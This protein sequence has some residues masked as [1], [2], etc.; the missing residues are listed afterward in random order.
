M[1]SL[2]KKY[3]LNSGVSPEDGITRT[4]AIGL[5]NLTA[6]SAGFNTF[7]F[8][9]ALLYFGQYQLFII[10]FVL[11]L[12][13][14]SGFLFI[15][16]GATTFGRILVIVLGNISVFYFSN[17]SRGG[18]LI[19]MFFYSLCISPFMYFSWEERRYYALSIL[20]IV[21]LAVGALNDWTFFSAYPAQSD[22]KVFRFISTIATLQQIITGFYYFLKLSVKFEAESESHLKNLAIEHRKQLQTQKLSSLGEMSAGVSHEINNPLMVIMGKA[23]TIK[24][25]LAKIPDVD[26]IVIKRLSDID[27]MVE[28]ITRIIKALR[29]FS[30]NSEND[31]MEKASV[32][33]I[34]NSTLDLCREK[35]LTAGIKLNIEVDPE[36]TIKCRP[37]EISQVILNLLNNAFDA[38]TG[39]DNS[40]ITI[41]AHKLHQQVE[42]LIS[43]NGQGISAH[44]VD[45]IMHP[46]FTTKEVGKATGLGLSISKGLVEGHQGT[47]TYV[48][49]S[50]PTIFQI[51]LPKYS[52]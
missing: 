40:S 42:I 14:V 19:Q 6:L 2:I 12:L 41:K 52:D 50:G 22:L 4:R 24:R 51:L 38:S 36:L 17:I 16:F 28:K 3:I 27:L 34:I 26:P 30:R 46:F 23:H 32:N 21:L 49:G 43:D 39:S 10:C 11:S 44:V 47:L 8:S 20:S 1:K 7:L 13:Y 37:T 9:L 25:D 29:T 33:Q 18:A 15:G 5:S 48:P 31:P 35:F 45:K